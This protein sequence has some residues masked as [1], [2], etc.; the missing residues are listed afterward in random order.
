ML[1]RSRLKFVQ[2]RLYG[3]LNNVTPVTEQTKVLGDE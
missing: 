3:V 2:L 1:A